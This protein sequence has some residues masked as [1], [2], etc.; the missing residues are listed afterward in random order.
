MDLAEPT[1]DLAGLA[2]ARLIASEGQ[3]LRQRLAFD[4]TTTVARL[5]TEIS[6]RVEVRDLTVE[7]PDIEDVVRRLYANQRRGS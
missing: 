2:G 1:P 7:E 3:G 6:T 5:L 4:D